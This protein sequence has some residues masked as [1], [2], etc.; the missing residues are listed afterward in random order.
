LPN[1]TVIPNIRAVEYH[2]DELDN[3]VFIIG[4]GR[5]FVEAI[6]FADELLLTFVDKDVECD[7]YF[8]IKSIKKQFDVVSVTPAENKELVFVKYKRK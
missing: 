4:G 3:P 8:P 2:T 6:A 1:A 7:M 5:I